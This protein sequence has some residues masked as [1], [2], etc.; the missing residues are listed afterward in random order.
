MLP[1]LPSRV[2]PVL[3]APGTASSQQAQHSRVG[4]GSSLIHTGFLQ[5]L[6][7]GY[8]TPGPTLANSQASKAT[9]RPDHNPSACSTSATTDAPDGKQELEPRHVAGTV[10]PKTS[11]SRATGDTV[12]HG[13][14]RQWAPSFSPFLSLRHSPNQ[15]GAPRPRVWLLGSGTA[16]KSGY[17][18]LWDAGVPSR[19]A[20]ASEQPWLSSDYAR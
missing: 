19:A 12:G 15:Y 10:S 4:Q 7:S 8:V 9:P 11:E 20:S 13:G 18:A 2:G 16:G 1:A 17:P 3:G 6:L 14:T 5:S